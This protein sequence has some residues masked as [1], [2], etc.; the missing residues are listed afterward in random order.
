MYIYRSI[1]EGTP[2]K[3][4]RHVKSTTSP[5]ILGVFFIIF[6]LIFTLYLM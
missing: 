6:Q 2:R 5:P 3:I 1:K 4:S